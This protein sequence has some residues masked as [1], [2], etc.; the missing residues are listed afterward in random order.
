MLD[1]PDGRLR[2]TGCGLRLRTVKTLDGPA[3]PATVTFKGARESG[4]YKRRRELEVAV[5]DAQ[6]MMEILTALDYHETLAYEKLRESWQF[7]DCRVELDELPHLGCFV[8]VEGPNEEAIKATLD[9]LGL[10]AAPLVPESYVALAA[11]WAEELASRT[12]R[13][14]GEV[15]PPPELRF[16]ADRS[17]TAEHNGPA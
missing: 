11:E 16:P 1:R 15:C 9:E 13:G 3:Q 14:H 17:S 2:G 6:G 12:R 10:T 7:G 8:E 5:S 4:P